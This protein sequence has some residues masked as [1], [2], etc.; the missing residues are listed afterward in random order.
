MAY[1]LDRVVGEEHS[2]YVPAFAFQYLAV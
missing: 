1:L 2:P